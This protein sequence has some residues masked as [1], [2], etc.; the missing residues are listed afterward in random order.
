MVAPGAQEHHGERDGA[1]QQWTQH[2]D[3]LQANVVWEPV[4]VRPY[5][6]TKAAGRHV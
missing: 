5:R 1:A 3:S 6:Q 4:L 2:P